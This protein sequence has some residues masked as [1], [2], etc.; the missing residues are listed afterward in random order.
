VAGQK[1][2]AM[3]LKNMTRSYLLD[4]HVLIWW[5]AGDERLSP[6]TVALLEDRRNDVLIAGASLHEYAIKEAKGDMPFD[7]GTLVAA[8]SQLGLT[9]LPF[10]WTAVLLYGQVALPQKDPFDKAIVVL[11]MAHSVP[12]ITAD[13]NILKTSLPGLTLINPGQ[14][15]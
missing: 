2:K 1:K 12:L 10:G 11:A 9:V 4:T 8:V 5:L 13:R 14:Q 6:K 15:G 3:P 7:S